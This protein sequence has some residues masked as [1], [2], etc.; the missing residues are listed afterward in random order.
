MEG[1]PRRQSLLDAFLDARSAVDAD[2]SASNQGRIVA[3]LEGAARCIATLAQC[4]RLH[5][6]LRARRVE[7]VVYN[8][9]GGW[10]V[11]LVLLD[12][13][14]D[15]TSLS[16]E[17]LS[18]LMQTLLTLDVIAHDPKSRLVEFRSLAGALAD[19]PPIVPEGFE[20]ELSECW[21]RRD[22]LSDDSLAS[23]LT[24]Q[25]RALCQ[26]CGV[27]L[28]AEETSDVIEYARVSLLM[29]A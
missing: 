7:S 25:L 24:R 13:P 5:L 15:T 28:H 19:E 6:R 12:M 26:D 2:E 11:E 18:W 3:Q 20:S 17:L 23:R 4:G 10:I 21:R 29:L 1:F 8:V 16:C 22:E 9:G 14:T 27:R